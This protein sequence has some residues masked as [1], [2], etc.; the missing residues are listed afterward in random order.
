MVGTCAHGDIRCDLPYLLRQG[1]QAR[2]YVIFVTNVLVLN[3]TMKFTLP[4]SNFHIN[5]NFY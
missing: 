2:K 1:V 3:I 5:C 4:K